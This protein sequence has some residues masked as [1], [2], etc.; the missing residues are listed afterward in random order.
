MA[1]YRRGHKV[2]AMA[3][4]QRDAVGLLTVACVFALVAATAWRP[5]WFALP[6]LVVVG[7]LMIFDFAVVDSGPERDRDEAYPDEAYPGADYPDEHYSDERYSDGD[8]RA[9]SELGESDLD[10]LGLA[11]TEARGPRA[12]P[13]ATTAWSPPTV[14]RGPPSRPPRRRASW[15]DYPVDG[16]NSDIDLPTAAIDMRAFLD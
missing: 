12:D 7:A 2:P 1:H 16:P 15:L 8:Y 11:A 14:R 4:R 10:R 3:T 5:L 6:C 13:A 9:E